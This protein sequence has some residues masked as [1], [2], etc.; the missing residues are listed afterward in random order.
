MSEVVYIKQMM[1]T[2]LLA[3]D[4]GPLGRPYPVANFILGKFT[5]DFSPEEFQK[6]C[7]EDTDHFIVEVKI[8]RVS[9]KKEEEKEV[10][11]HGLE[12]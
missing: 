3:C 2:K 4:P 8:K 9:K 12:A 6:R 5:C 11:P 10:G 1:I 7:R